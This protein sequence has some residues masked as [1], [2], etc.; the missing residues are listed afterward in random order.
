MAK[1]TSDGRLQ[2]HERGYTKRWRRAALRYLKHHSTCAMLGVDAKCAGLAT[3]VDH[4]TPPRGSALVL[5]QT[6]LAGVVPAMPLAK[7]TT[8]AATGTQEPEGRSRREPSHWQ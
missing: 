7:D 1:R 8:G 5:G 3:C 2:P 4:V 6:E